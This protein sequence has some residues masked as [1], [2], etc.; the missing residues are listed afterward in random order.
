LNTK[1]PDFETLNAYVDGELDATAT[2]EIE[3]A[4]A[5]D[6][7]L[8][9]QVLMLNQFKSAAA[10][11]I[12]IPKI[13]LPQPRTQTK[14]QVA[15]SSCRRL[16]LAAACLAGLALFTNIAGPFGSTSKNGEEWLSPAWAM[17][18]AWSISDAGVKPNNA[19]A[20]KVSTFS[21]N[22]LSGSYVPDLTMAKL[23]VS[24][25][26]SDH[27]YRNDKA[28]LIGYAG[29]RGC[30]ISLLITPSAGHLSP[31]MTHFERDKMSLYGWQQ[32]DLDYMVM[33]EG[34]PDQRFKS[35][36]E[37]V[38][39]SSTIRL[40]VDSDTRMALAKDQAQSRPCQA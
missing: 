25:V 19:A 40:P 12:D 32:D 6:S 35:I 16:V 14:P 24:Y 39:K 30:K 26:S 38:Y 13:E 22:M 36:A 27:Q 37:A 21:E 9:R 15:L 4:I 23:Y 31:L 17:Q 8:A 28:L 11:S 10:Q 7:D 2:A 1:L 3:C 33:A 29:L 20:L 5:N 34:M 18:K